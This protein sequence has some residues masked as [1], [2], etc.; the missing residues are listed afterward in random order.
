MKKPKNIVDAGCGAGIKVL[1][2]KKGL[3]LFIMT[4]QKI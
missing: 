1:I 2:K 4:N 3:K